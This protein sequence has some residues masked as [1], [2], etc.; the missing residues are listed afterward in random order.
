MLQCSC[1][2]TIMCARGR[3]SFCALASAVPV[4]HDR[5]RELKAEG[6]VRPSHIWMCYDLLSRPASLMV[7]FG[8]RPLA[9]WWPMG[10]TDHRLGE[11]L[12]VRM[13]RCICVYANAG[14]KHFS[15]QTP[16]LGFLLCFQYFVAPS[17]TVKNIDKKSPLF[18]YL[19][20]FNY[21]TLEFKQNSL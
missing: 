20:F 11:S 2:C 10:N 13:S 6:T 16:T 4:G 5:R 3:A 15:L 8:T 17:G 18:I 7:G 14:N 19:F 21:I 12:N 9:L 1:L